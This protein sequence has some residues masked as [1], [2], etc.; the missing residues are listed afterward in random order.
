MNVT[1]V[2]D[3]SNSSNWGAIATS[4]ALKEMI[5]KAGGSINVNIKQN[6]IIDFQFVSKKKP[7]KNKGDNTD[8]LLRYFHLFVPPVIPKAYHKV[9]SQ[10]NRFRS[11]PTIPDEWSKFEAFANH[12][13]TSENTL[14]HHFEN[15]KKSDVVI[16]NGEGCLYGNTFQSRAIFLIG[17]I[18]KSIIK[19]PT[20]IVNHTVDL[21]DPNLLHLAEK[22]YP[23][24]DDVVCREYRTLEVCKKFCECRFA[25]DASYFYSPLPRK[26][27]LKRYFLSKELVNSCFYEWSEK[28]VFDPSKPYICVGGSSLIQSYTEKV[29]DGFIELLDQL[30]TLPVQVLL[31][32]SAY[33]DFEVFKTIAEKLDLP[34]IGIN[35]PVDLAM[36][37][38]GHAEIYIGGRWHPSNFALRGGTPVILLSGK[39]FKMHA[40]ADMVHIS[41]EVFDIRELKINKEKICELAKNIL[42]RGRALRNEIQN[43]S[44]SNSQSAV[45]NIKFLQM[46]DISRV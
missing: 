34:L 41:H 10:L 11:K 5:L 23:L 43:W 9:H 42:N 20:I 17:Y 35:T 36:D 6:Q 38:I 12:C 14:S 1:L 21:S 37:I 7:F 24:F 44:E 29:F 32:A 22:V 30:G 15:M 8:N 25:I 19:K 28:S 33:K 31:T 13:L 2:N 4:T 27:F 18:S 26:H 46:N 45:E 39:T 16:L 40:L 3:T